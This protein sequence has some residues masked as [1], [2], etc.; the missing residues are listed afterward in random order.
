MEDLFYDLIGQLLSGRMNSG[1]KIDYRYING[2]KLYSFVEM[3]QNFIEKL[4]TGYKEV[5][6]A[7]NAL[8]N[9]VDDNDEDELYDDYQNSLGEI[10]NTIPIFAC[11]HADNRDDF[12]DQIEHF[13]LEYKELV[14]IE[15][16]PVMI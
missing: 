14:P 9:R 7:F 1:I 10:M 13:C 2:D 12:I 5:C 4:K 11:I 6:D 16:P 3:K 15:L 8:H